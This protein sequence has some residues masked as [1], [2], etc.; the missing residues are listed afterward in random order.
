MV[1][2]KVAHWDRCWMN[3]TLQ[4]LMCFVYVS[5]AQCGIMVD[6]V[7]LDNNFQM[8]K[9]CPKIAK[10]CPK[11]PKISQYWLKLPKNVQNYQNTMVTSATIFSILCIGGFP[12]LSKSKKE[13]TEAFLQGRSI[14]L[15]FAIL[16][17]KRPNITHETFLSI[18][19]KQHTTAN[20]IR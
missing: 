10:K 14:C 6:E 18:I 1:I 19:F 20:N 8:S 17:K 9:K 15:K 4:A 11:F 3:N 12:T 16:R 7:T 5:Q 2:D 13:E